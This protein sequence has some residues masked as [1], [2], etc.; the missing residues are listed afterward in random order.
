M[1]KKDRIIFHS[2]PLPRQPICSK[3]PDGVLHYEPGTNK[4]KFLPLTVEDVEKGPHD[5]PFNPSA[6][7][8]N[9]LKEAPKMFPPICDPPRF[10]FKKRALS[11][12]YPYVVVISCKKLEN[13]NG[14]SLR[15]LKTDHRQIDRHKLMVGQWRLL[16]TP[17]SKPKFQNCNWNG[18][19]KTKE[20]WHQVIV[21]S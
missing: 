1:L 18:S 19:L 5:I 20:A 3:R 7:T 12:L 15:Y 9:L 14:W 16:R 2:T 6:K 13:T 8:A 21:E 11:V 10:F 17:S 4:D